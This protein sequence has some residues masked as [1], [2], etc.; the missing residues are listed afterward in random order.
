M[1]TNKTLAEECLEFRN[2]VLNLLIAMGIEKL[3]IKFNKFL[4]RIAR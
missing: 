1:K 4:R 3:V 2:A